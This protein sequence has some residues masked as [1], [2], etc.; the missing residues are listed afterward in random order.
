[1]QSIR[2]AMVM[3]LPTALLTAASAGES[4]DDEAAVPP[5]TLPNVLA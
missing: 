3:I 5:Y 4:N 1:M 2:W